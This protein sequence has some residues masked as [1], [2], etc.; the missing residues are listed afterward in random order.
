MKKVSAWFFVIVLLAFSCLF[1]VP[2]GNAAASANSWDTMA[3]MP[4][5]RSLLGVG[6]VNG[7]IY[8]IGGERGAGAVGVNELYDPATDTWIPK[9]SMPTSRYGFA[10]AVLNNKIYCIGGLFSD[11]NE[12]YDPVTDTW[13]TKQ[14]MPTRRGGFSASVVNGKI[15]LVGGLVPSSI[16]PSNVGEHSNLN[17]MYDPVTDSWTTM[18]SMPSAVA[19]SVSA[20]VDDKIYVFGNGDTTQIYDTQTNTWS[21]GPAMPYSVSYGAA[22]ATTGTYAPKRIYRIGGIRGPSTQVFDPRTGTWITGAGMPTPRRDLSVAVVDDLL[23]AIGGVSGDYGSSGVNERYV[24]LGYSVVPPVVGVV[25]P[26]QSMTY[27]AGNISLAF[28]VDRSAAV[29]NYNLDGAANMTLT[30]NTTL[31]GLAEGAHNI[32]IYATYPVDNTGA[33]QTIHFTIAPEQQQDPEP[34]E[35]FPAIQV[36]AVASA[37]AT[38]AVGMGLIVY[39]KKRKREAGQ[40]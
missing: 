4:T 28:T 32:T 18:A 1:A 25:S 39:F 10:T 17:E 26:E 20:V 15:Y 16:G 2:K 23:Y 12:V 21:F 9:E 29:L 27:A 8:A 19:P 11:L 7:K 37:A 13:E 38:L 24:P 40:I 34:H 36:V 3:E 14:P 31:T 5:A 22:A 33:S 35:P 30:G 6:V